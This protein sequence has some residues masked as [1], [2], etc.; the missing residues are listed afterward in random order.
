MIGI[1]GYGTFVPR[2]RLDR[3]TIAAAHAWFA[4]GLIGLAKGARAIANWDEDAIT[5]AVEAAR[6]CVSPPPETIYLASTSLPFLDRQNAGIVKEALALDD[7]VSTI[8]IAGSQRAGTGALLTALKA[9]GRSLCIAAEKARPQPA[10]ESELTSGD[11]AV[12]FSTGSENVIAELIG[13]HSL[14]TDFIDH[15]RAAGS[16][17]SYGWESRWIRDEGYGK[18][19]PRAV[20]AALN[21]SGVAASDIA[22]FAFAPVMKGV[23]ADTARKLGMPTEAIDDG[24]GAQMGDAGPA[25]SLLLLAHALE[26]ATPGQII[27]VAG[28]GQGCDVLIF[29][30]TKALAGYR[31]ASPLSAALARAEPTQ[32]YSRYLALAGLLDIDRGMRA[33]QDQKTPL[34]A[35]YRDRRTVLGLIGGRCTKTGTIQFPKSEFSVSPNDPAFDTQEDYRFADI[36]ATIITFTA[37]RLAYTP[38]PPY[39][40]GT[41]AFDGGGRMVAEFADCGENDIQVGKRV[42]MMFRIK[43]RDEL[44]GFTRYFWKAVPIREGV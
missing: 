13:N 20:K 5:L 39:W 43:N 33:E 42:R 27:L 3:A 21:T 9:G 34:T 26:K 16:E 7:A 1:T 18:I 2:L 28:F 19:V 11:G 37:D 24:I 4:P 31:S 41:V 29:R 38:S 25:Q 10:S 8:D 35:L 40:Y 22:H 6:G 14:S 30:T 15:F 17:F 44:R 32:E 12:A 23:A 36:P